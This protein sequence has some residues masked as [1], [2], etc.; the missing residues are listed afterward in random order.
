MKHTFGLDEEGLT[1]LMEKSSRSQFSDPRRKVEISW[2][3]AESREEERRG[4]CCEVGV[5]GRVGLV[6]S[7]LGL[8]GEGSGDG[9]AEKKSSSRP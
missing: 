2:S 8:R 9:T 1:G 4:G 3:D 7:D 6:R 5:A